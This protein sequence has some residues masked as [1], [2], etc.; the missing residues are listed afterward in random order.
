MKVSAYL[1]R[2]GID[3]A[4]IK[5]ISTRYRKRFARAD[6]GGVP[7]GVEVQE[8]LLVSKVPKAVRLGKTNPWTR[9]EPP[10]R[11][12]SWSYSWS[13]SG[14][15]GWD[16]ERH[17]FGRDDESHSFQTRVQNSVSLKNDWYSHGDDDWGYGKYNTERG[18]WFKTGR[19]GPI[20]AYVEAEVRYSDHLI[21]LH[22]RSGSSDSDTTQ[23]QY[24]TM[25]IGGDRSLCRVSYFYRY[26]Y[27]FGEWNASFW[28][29]G[30]RTWAH[31]ISQQGYPPGIWVFVWVGLRN[32]SSC[33]ADD[34]WSWSY[35]G[36]SW[37]IRSVTIR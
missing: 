29:Q 12:W 27:A 31:L 20:E 3:E 16:D 37:R 10:F 11:G 35:V 18:F 8:P 33:W 17:S 32:C 36:G 26:G 6:R 30:E 5:K 24:I 19:G 28:P 9:V 2:L 22:D 7:A 14:F 21:R 13:G 1:K 25:R 15:E 4:A 23:N 34:V